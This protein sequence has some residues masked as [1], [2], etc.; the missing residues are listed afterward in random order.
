MTK[1]DRKMWWWDKVARF[2]D[3]IND[4]IDV[5][6]PAFMLLAM[7]IILSIVVKFM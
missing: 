6:E 1:Y 7:A 5:L 4:N 2:A 3:W